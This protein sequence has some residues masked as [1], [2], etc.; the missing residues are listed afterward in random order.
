MKK[1]FAFLASTSLLTSSAF[2]EDFL[3]KLTKGALSDKSPGVKELS[4]EEMKEVKG[5]WYWQGGV[6]A[7]KTRLQHDFLGNVYGKIVVAGII[8]PDASDKYSNMYFDVSLNISWDNPRFVDNYTAEY[9][10]I[11]ISLSDGKRIPVYQKGVDI[12]YL[13]E[14]QIYQFDPKIYY[15]SKA[16]LSAQNHY[17]NYRRNFFK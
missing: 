8:A 15:A 11:P 7:T 4:L 10:F 16:Y 17:D 6:D 12:K 2:A 5:G 1:I 9:R 14:K 3:A 13:N